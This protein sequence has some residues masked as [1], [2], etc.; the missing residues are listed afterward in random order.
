MFDSESMFILYLMVVRI[1][2]I[3]A[4]VSAIRYGYK[5]FSAGV[6]KTNPD[7]TETELS[8]RAGDYEFKFKTAAPGSVLALFGALIVIVTMTSSPPE[9]TKKTHKV[10][11]DLRQGTVAT[12]QTSDQMRGEVGEFEKLTKIAHGFI[13]NGETIRALEV[14]EQ[15]IRMTTEPMHELAKIYIEIER[16]EEA[17]KIAQVPNLLNPSE[18]DYKITL[19]TIN[20]KLR[21]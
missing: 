18:P 11:E 10:I 5:L 21:N 19:D 12:V 2:T 4:G 8:G 20:N 1:V 17:K 16:L 6:F 7:T 13:Q 3:F 14:Y 15:A 9:R